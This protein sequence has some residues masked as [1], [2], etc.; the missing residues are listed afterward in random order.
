MPADLFPILTP[1]EEEL[2]RKQAELAALERQLAERELELATLRAELDRIQ[3]AYMAQVGLK[4]A[5]LDRIEARISEL[6]AASDPGDEDLQARAAEAQTRAEE[7]EQATRGIEPSRELLKSFTPSDS[8]KDLFRQAA[9]ELHPDL[10]ESDDDRA[11]RT[12]VMAEVNR[13]YAAGDE[14]RIRQILRDWRVRPESV[15]GEGT[16]ADLQ[17]VLRKLAQVRGRLKTI[18]SEFEDLRQSPAYKLREQ[19]ELA[20]KEGRDLFA[21]LAERVA[22]D[23]VAARTR[24]DSLEEAMS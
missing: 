24:L 3:H 4:Y 16:M 19:L 2:R 23:T 17:R 1:E 11:I 12:R 8:R 10:A 20:T 18:D 22:I 5:E 13:A 9:K 14:D 15:R 21:E 7:S 6:L